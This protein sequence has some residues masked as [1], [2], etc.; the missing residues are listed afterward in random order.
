MQVPL[1]MLTNYR[2]IGD[3]KFRYTTGISKIYLWSGSGIVYEGPPI[4]EFRSASQEIGMY[5]EPDLPGAS[6]EIMDS[7]SIRSFWR[8]FS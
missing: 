5:F 6:A 1:M 4:P 7:C 8:Q 3:L 2:G